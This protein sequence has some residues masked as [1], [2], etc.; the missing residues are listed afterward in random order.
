MAMLPE[1]PKQRN[2]LIVGLLMV[3]GLYFFY[4]SWYTPE[5]LEIE[6]LETRLTALQAQNLRARVVATRGG[7]ELEQRLALYE[8][9]ID[10][11]ERLIPRSEEVPALLAAIST[12][13]LR[14]RVTVGTLNPQPVQTGSFYDRQSYEM[15]V[16]GDFHDV[17]RFLT[18][19]ASMSRVI[20]PSD[21]DV[22][23]YT[24]QAD[25]RIQ[26]PVM[27][28]FRIQTYVLPTGTPEATDARA[29]AGDF[30]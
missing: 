28:R 11:L 5:Q 23:P 25:A 14:A 13:A 22:N 9:H 26:F 15:S 19:I 7:E 1:D 21:M 18:A 30:Q 4:S 10:Q 16:V 29:S 17:G 12:E 20:T 3:V 8:R 27:A 6:R 24:G 2:S